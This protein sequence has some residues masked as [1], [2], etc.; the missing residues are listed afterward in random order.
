MRSCES[1]PY[2]VCTF[3][4]SI[5]P[6]LTNGLPQERCIKTGIVHCQSLLCQFF[7]SLCTSTLRSH[8]IS[9]S[10][11]RNIQSIYISVKHRLLHRQLHGWLHLPSFFPRG[12]RHV[13]ID[14][15]LSSYRLYTILKSKRSSCII[16]LRTIIPETY[17]PWY[18]GANVVCQS[19]RQQAY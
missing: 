4:D 17:G 10:W 3:Y 6:T 7:L 19:S 13:T 16:T 15:Q 5:H 14:L 2:R 18:C 12:S 9:L 1:T 11:S 8:R